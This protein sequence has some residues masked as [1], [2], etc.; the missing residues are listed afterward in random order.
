MEE[1]FKEKKSFNPDEIQS[2][3]SDNAMTKNIQIAFNQFESYKERGHG[4]A[5]AK[6]LAE[7][8][9][10][11]PKEGIVGDQYLLIISLKLAGYHYQRSKEVRT[12]E[13]IAYN[14]QMAMKYSDPVPNTFWETNQE[15]V[16]LRKNIF[17]S[18]ADYFIK[19]KELGKAYEI[20]KLVGQLELLS[21]ANPDML[22]NLHM[23][24]YAKQL[25]KYLIYN[26]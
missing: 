19:I 15:W 18:M 5:G 14:L 24:L 22:A 25:G 10:E 16:Q 21:Q 12:K 23:A 6:I 2:S 26:I 1:F 9:S 17:K 4:D 7:L 3:E 20:M 13:Q 8:L 11:I